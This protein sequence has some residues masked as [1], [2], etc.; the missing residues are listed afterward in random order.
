MLDYNKCFNL[1]SFGYNQNL[2][3]ILYLN[4]QKILSK[5]HYKI[6]LSIKNYLIICFLD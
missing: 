4:F 3:S 6:A 1:D 5:Y 2:K